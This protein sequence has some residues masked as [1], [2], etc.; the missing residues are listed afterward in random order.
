MLELYTYTAI[1]MA[2]YHLIRSR[3]FVGSI[4][5]GIIWPWTFLACV[6]R[7]YMSATFDRRLAGIQAE[8]E[9]RMSHYSPEF[10]AEMDSFVK[11]IDEI[12]GK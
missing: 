4:F 9:E 5:M 8:L 7:M 11:R 3:N 10:I 2:I 6:R 1:F 12:N